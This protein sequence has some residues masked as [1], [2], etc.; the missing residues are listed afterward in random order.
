VDIDKLLSAA[1][2]HRDAFIASTYVTLLALIAV[3]GMRISEAIGLDR[4]DI[5]DEQGL[6]VVRETKFGK[7]RELPLQT[8]TVQ[9]LRAYARIRDRHLPVQRASSFFLS[10][11]GSPLIYQNVHLKFY[12]FVEQAGLASRGPR[13][14]RIHDLRHS[15]AVRIFTEWHR[16]GLDVEPRLP[17]LSTYMGHVNPAMTYW[18]LTAVPEL[19]LL[20]GERASRLQE[21]RS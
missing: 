9:A 12:R 8:S 4:R 7:S 15:F 2:S 21:V 18:Y 5:D 14:P 19:L 10:R 6:L 3:T 1:R 16:D 17:L 20:V 11:R 13:R